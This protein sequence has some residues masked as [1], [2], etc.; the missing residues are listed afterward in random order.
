MVRILEMELKK[1]TEIDI[2]SPKR[3]R[4]EAEAEVEVDVEVDV[5][6][7][8]K[9]KKYQCSY[10]E[11][12]FSVRCRLKDHVAIIHEGQSRCKYEDHRQ[13]QPL[14]RENDPW[15]RRQFQCKL[16]DVNYPARRELKSHVVR[17][18][19]IHI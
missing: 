15:N 12:S 17:L 10:C 4:M 11:R 1:C 5:V 16:C 8:Q 19:L 18:S 2:T 13:E 3:Q 7:R 6:K 9:G 14:C